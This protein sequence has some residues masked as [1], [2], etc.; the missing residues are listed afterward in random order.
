MIWAWQK[1]TETFKSIVNWE[2]VLRMKQSK[3]QMTVGLIVANRGFFPGWLVEDG[4]RKLLNVIES[5]GVKVITLTER[6]TKYGA[7]GNLQDAEK[8]AN[9]F[10][11]HAGEIDGIVV[12][13]P[14]FGDERSA[15]GA[16]RLS[17]LHV[18]VLVHAFPDEVD[19]LDLQHRRDSFCGK[20]SLC[21]NLVQYQ[22]PFTD[23]TY[24]TEAV[25]SGQFKKDF[26]DFLAI[27]RI[28]RGVKNLKIGVVGTRP[29]AFN[30]VR[31]SEKILE[32]SGISVETI[33]LS[34]IIA[35]ANKFDSA[36]AQYKEHLQ[37]LKDTFKPSNVPERSL[38][39]MARLSVILNEWIEE[40]QVSA[41]AIQC[42]T[43]LE[44]I[45]GIVPCAVMSMLS[46]S[47]IPSACEA[48]VMGALSM[49][50]L[51]LASNKPSALMDWN[52]NFKEEEDKAIMF[53]CS[54]FPISFFE[55]CQMSHQDIIA[56]TVGQ[57]NTYGTCVGRVSPGPATFL[58]LSTFDNEGTIVSVIAEGRFTEDNVKTFG[59]YGVVEIPNLRG[60]LKVITQ[61]GFEHHVA[62]SKSTV[63][64]VVRET[65]ERYLGWKIIS[66]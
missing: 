10:K 27:C 58:R 37:K 63:G 18:P 4:K 51:Q 48:D 22:I 9:L 62:V 65:I 12:T 60:L 56:G 16:V 40:S 15:A 28:V 32:R 55:S 57:E 21:N 54:N 34:E 66:Y 1:I 5:M 46:E 13:L 24:H 44:A 6:E 47:L 52:N 19:K 25:D 3:R 8:C 2:G 23:T 31:F 35:R 11:Q 42:W 30:T 38:D 17:G 49:Y 33:D 45:Y 39:K 43:A 7:V 26:Q 41:V 53:H 64:D 59:G 36:S 50:V 29:T 61:N 14:N 20:V